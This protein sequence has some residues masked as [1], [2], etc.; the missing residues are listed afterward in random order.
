M[1]DKPPYRVPLMAEINALPWNGFNAVS[2]FSGCGG[3]CLGYRMAGFKVLWSSEFIPAAQDAYRANASDYTVLDTRDI[4]EVKPGDVLKATGLGMGEIDI[5]DGSPPCASFST[6]GRREAGWGKEKKYSDTVQRVD[7]LFFEY[8]R[9]LDGLQPRTFVA[10]N[11]YGLVKGTAK[12]YFKQILKCLKDCGYQVEARRLNASWLGVPQAR[13]RIIF[14]GVRNDLGKPPVYP[15][16][17]PYQ[18]TVRDALPWIAGQGDNGGFGAGGIRDANVPSPTIGASPNTGN[19]NFPAS[20]V[21]ATQAQDDN[22]SMVMQSHGWFP[23]RTVD[24]SNEPSPTVLTDGFGSPY[25]VHSRTEN[26][27]TVDPET[28]ETVTLGPRLPAYA[29]E[30]KKLRMGEKSRRYLNLA[31]PDPDEPMPTLVAN[32]GSGTGVHPMECR[33]LTIAELRR[34][35]GFPDDFVLTGTYAQRWERIGRAVPPVMMM[36]VS[37]AIRDQILIP[38]REQGK[39]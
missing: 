2:T 24:L 20:K 29:V 27:V 8:A 34:I 18:Y 21:V 39:I 37:A 38:L 30:W 14:V 15:N 23:G 10:E 4:R 9:L 19:G 5:F 26:G 17:L 12:G 32:S 36:H 6:A 28:G 11:V 1:S 3:S 13:Q 25:F 35:S 7:D 22:P 31:R 33:R 16:P